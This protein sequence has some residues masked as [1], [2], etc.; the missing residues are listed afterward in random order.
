MEE[1]QDLNLDNVVKQIPKELTLEELAKLQEELAKLQKEQEKGMEDINEE[2][3]NVIKELFLEDGEEFDKEKCVAK[4]KDSRHIFI[5]YPNLQNKIKKRLDGIVSNYI[6]IEY[7]FEVYNKYV[8]LLEQSKEELKRIKL[9]FRI[10]LYRINDI[11]IKLPIKFKEE[12][13]GIN[14]EWKGIDKYKNFPESVFQNIEP[15]DEDT[16]KIAYKFSNNNYVKENLEDVLTKT[17]TA[18]YPGGFFKINNP[19]L[20]NIDDK[21]HHIWRDIEVTI[22]G[23]NITGFNTTG[24]SWP[25]AEYLVKAD[26]GNCG[27]QF[28]NLAGALIKTKQVELSNLPPFVTDISHMFKQ[29]TIGKTVN[30]LNV[31]NVT[32]MSHMFEESIIEQGIKIDKWNVSN[33]IDM[34]YMFCGTTFYNHLFLDLDEWNVSNVIDMSYMFYETT[35]HNDTFL[36]LSKWKLYKNININN[37]F[38]SANLKRRASI[39]IYNWDRTILRNGIGVFDNVENLMNIIRPRESSNIFVKTFNLIPKTLTNWARWF[40]GRTKGEK[41]YLKYKIKYLNLKKMINNKH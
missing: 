37:M 4:I 21:N 11:T 8:N 12:E 31:S 24:K 41:K 2:S 20:F 9:N 35:F 16:S 25:G 1:K 13:L 19:A 33:V 22:F 17:F 26:F 6:L 3:D 27:N 30:Q 29:A 28:N 34:S 32:N 5:K 15:D 39:L 23:F 38:N 7:C 10:P 14:V 36:I 40:S 18:L